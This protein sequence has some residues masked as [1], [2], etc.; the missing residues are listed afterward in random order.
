MT[1]SFLALFARRIISWI[2]SLLL[3]FVPEKALITDLK[4]LQGNRKRKLQKAHRT[5]GSSKYYQGRSRLKEGA[6]FSASSGLSTKNGR[7][8]PESNQ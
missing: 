8:K 7:D 6:D 2:T 5:K 3:V 1:P 4:L